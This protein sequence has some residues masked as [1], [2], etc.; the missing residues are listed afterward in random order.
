MKVGRSR[1]GIDA[2]ELGVQRVNE[3]TAD[4]GGQLGAHVG[5]RLPGRVLRGVI[6]AIGIAAIFKLVL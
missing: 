6:V 4:V 5:R 3:G 2:R 1:L